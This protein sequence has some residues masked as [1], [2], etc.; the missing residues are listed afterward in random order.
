MKTDKKMLSSGEV[1][2]ELGV[3]ARTVTRWA[4]AGKLTHIRLPG[5]HRRFPR[6]GISAM[7]SQCN[8]IPIKTEEV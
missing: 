2:A 1:A 3:D 4:N 5:G 7:I 8:P 6:E